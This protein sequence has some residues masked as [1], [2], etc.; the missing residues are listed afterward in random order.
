MLQKNLL[1]IGNHE[2]I[3]INATSKITKISLKIM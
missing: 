2:G 3:M 1:I